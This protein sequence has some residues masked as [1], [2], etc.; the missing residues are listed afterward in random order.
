[1]LAY[2]EADWRQ[3]ETPWPTVLRSDGDGEPYGVSSVVVVT[4]DEAG[5]VEPMIR[6]PAPESEPPLSQ[7]AAGP[8]YG[9]VCPKWSPD[10]QFI[11][12]EA[13]NQADGLRVVDLDGGAMT[14]RG[15]WMVAPTS[16][17]GDFWL[18]FGIMHFEWAPDSSHIA[19]ATDSGLWLVPLDGADPLLI[20]G[21]HLFKSLS[22]SPNGDQL[23]VSFSRQAS[24]TRD[25]VGRVMIGSGSEVVDVRPGREAI[26][27]PN[28]SSIAYV[29]PAGGTSLTWDDPVEVRILD[30]SS[31][32][33][34]EL[35][36]FPDRKYGLVWSPDSR[37]LVFLN[38]TSG[39]AG[40]RMGS[41]SIDGQNPPVNLVGPTED[42]YDTSWPGEDI[43]WQSINR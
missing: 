4:V 15:T 23:A 38:L 24:P 42:L 7:V 27:A 12:F 34:A 9:A 13:A 21:E 11:A 25:E 17:S 16:P 22:W 40:F 35:S 20:N 31:G 10:G 32:E 33:E 14:L 8:G 28:G 2:S 43:S 37:Q 19:V 18:H 3:P 26:W 39:Q 6:I 1:M 30:P 36:T 29:A 5:V 41:V